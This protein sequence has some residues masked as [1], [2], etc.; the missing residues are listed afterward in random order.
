MVILIIIKINIIIIISQIERFNSTIWPKILA[1]EEALKEIKSAEEIII[2]E[3][4][5]MAV[6]RNELCGIVQGRNEGKE[7]EISGIDVWYLLWM[8]CRMADTITTL[9]VDNG[10]LSPY[11]SESPIRLICT[12]SPPSHNFSHLL[13]FSFSPQ[14]NLDSFLVIIAHILSPFL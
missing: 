2:Q 9:A 10:V 4:S 13:L 5:V 11:R 12:S 3:R 6:T 1:Y 14:I 7:V 8:H